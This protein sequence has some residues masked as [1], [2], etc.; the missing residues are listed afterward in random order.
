MGEIVVPRELAESQLLF[1]GE[2]GRAFVDALP[3]RAAGYLDRWDLTPDGPEMYGTCS[4]V[5]PVRRADGSGAVLKLQLLDEETEG[6]PAALRAWAGSGAVRLLDADP[7]DGTLLLERLD[8]GRPLA[9][10]EDEA[11]ALTVLAGL[12]ARLSATPAPTGMRGLGE[13]VAGMLAEVPK[14]LG[15]PADPTDR[16]LLADAAAA[17]AEVADEP[18]DRL[19][20][21]DL[22]Y[23]NV[24]AAERE[25]WL[26]I[27]P[28]PLSGDPGFELL[29]ALH[30]RWDPTRVRYRF[31]LLTEAL[32][33]DRDRDRARAWTLG[34]I[35]QN[36]LWDLEDEEDALDPR[37]RVIARMLLDDLKG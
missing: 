23:G 13:L 12:L 26:V 31:D 33:A 28:K 37:H 7:A 20:H 27:D 10:V 5:L 36:A 25:P 29:P 1:N 21:W 24:L 4:L 2:A 8:A 11:T 15:G 34:R 3:G 22:H 30:D 32:G 16:R 6:E 18:G 19:L 9:A 14:A 35:V 17:L